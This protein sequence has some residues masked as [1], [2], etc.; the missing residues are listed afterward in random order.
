MSRACSAK[1]EQKTSKPMVIECDTGK[2]VSLL[3]GPLF[4][5]TFLFGGCDR[6]NRSAGT[7]APAAQAARAVGVDRLK[8]EL[9]GTK[10]AKQ[11]REIFVKLLGPPDRDIGSGVSIEQW[12]LAGGVLTLHSSCGPILEPEGG[13][14]VWLIET[15][16]TLQENLLGRYEMTTRPS[17]GGHGT[18]YWLG[19]VELR[20]DRTYAFQDSRSNLDQRAG[21]ENNFFMKHPEGQFEIVYAPGT[22]PATLLETLRVGATVAK[23][24]FTSKDGEPTAQYSIVSGSD[25]RMLCFAGIGESEFEMR[26]GWNSNWQ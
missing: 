9:R 19:N 16:N 3:I 26:R 14:T 25:A 22:T 21:Q 7:G 6:E 17:D 2:P 1:R 20:P 12:D 23:V 11:A 18:R 15:H 24:K 10:T 4:V 5:C 13:G 8:V